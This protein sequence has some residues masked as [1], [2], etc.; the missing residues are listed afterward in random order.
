MF[1]NIQAF[2]KEFE[3]SHQPFHKVLDVG[4]YDVNGSVKNILSP[5]SYRKFIGVDM[6]EG[7]GVDIVM[8]GHDIDKLLEPDMEGV[9]PPKFDLVTC[10]E[11]LEHDNKFW[12]TVEKMRSVLKPG[13]YMLITVPGIFY[14][15]HEFPNDYYRF[16]EEAVRA[17]FEDFT[18]VHIEYYE[19][20]MQETERK[21]NSIFAYG[22]KP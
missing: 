8:N 19:N 12:V 11:T 7:P 13:G 20:A 15:K 6:R 5:D 14:P 3:I 2:I 17:M 1:G 16:T 9:K 4:A 21:D 22:R 18:D 10:C